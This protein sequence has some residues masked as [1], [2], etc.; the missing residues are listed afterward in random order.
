MQRK[1]EYRDVGDKVKIP[2]V[3]SLN[4]RQ[5]SDLIKLEILES[6]NVDISGIK[7]NSNVRLQGPSVLTNLL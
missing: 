1:K 3:D 6:V 2:M 7:V 4:P 5:G